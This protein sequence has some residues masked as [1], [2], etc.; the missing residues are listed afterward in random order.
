MW[1]GGFGGRDCISVALSICL[2]PHKERMGRSLPLKAYN[3]NFW[4]GVCD[5]GGTGRKK[6]QGWSGEGEHLFNCLRFSPLKSPRG[7]EPCPNYRGDKRAQELKGTGRGRRDKWEESV[8]V[9]VRVGPWGGL[10]GCLKVFLDKVGLG[11]PD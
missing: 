9:L 4:M 10:G 5:K 3:L 7:I 2:A 8:A 11:Y 6:E 1:E